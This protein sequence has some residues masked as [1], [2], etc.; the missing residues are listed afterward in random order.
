[1]NQ[2]MNVWSLVIGASWEVQLV[3]L[4]LLV[5]SIL[6]WVS[7]VQKWL[8]IRDAENELHGFEKRFWSGMD[9]R[10]RFWGGSCRQ[11]GNSAM[12]GMENL[13]RAGFKEFTRLRQQP[14]IDSDAVM[15]G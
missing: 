13:F 14:G 3:L 1:M 6:S 2:S 4:T 15:E 12:I 11:K 5:M 10:Q 8:V 7:I 9:L